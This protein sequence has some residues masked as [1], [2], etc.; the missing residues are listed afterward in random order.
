MLKGETF[1]HLALNLNSLVNVGSGGYLFRV[2]IT[3]IATL[4]TLQ[5][6]WLRDEVGLEHLIW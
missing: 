6:Y 5:S 2:V 4:F 3:S 1:F